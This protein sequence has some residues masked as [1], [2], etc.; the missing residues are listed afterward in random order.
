MVPTPDQIRDAAYERWE[1]RGRGH[2]RDRDDWVRAE[3]DLLY[4]LNYSVIARIG[5]RPSP[6]VRGNG[7]GHG[8]G[9]DMARPGDPARLVCRYCEQSAPRARFDPTSG[10]VPTFRDD[11]S[12]ILDVPDECDECRESFGESFASD[13]ERFTRPIRDG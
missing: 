13:V 3:Q 9:T 11:G 4:T 12:L 8:H 6:V 7:S 1:R 10:P 5:P 2:G